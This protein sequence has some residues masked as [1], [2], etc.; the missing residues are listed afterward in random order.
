MNREELIKLSDEYQGWC[1][2]NRNDQYFA[3]MFDPDSFGDFIKWLETY[4]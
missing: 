4:A 2:E 3:R 1:H